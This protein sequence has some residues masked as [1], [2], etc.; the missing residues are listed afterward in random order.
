MSDEPPLMPKTIRQTVTFRAS[1]HD[2]YEALMD[3]RRHAKFTGGTAK[4]SRKLGGTFSVFDGYA[5]GKNLELVPDRK[6]VQ[7]WRASDWPEGHYST[8]TFA[9]KKVSGGTRL[10]FTQSGVPEDQFTS[11]KQ[12][13][14][15]FYWTPM[16]TFFAGRR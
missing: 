11:V 8:I 2:V 5:E 4:I 16:K 9:L 1:P 15:E 3:S 6:I 12:G 13:W 14:I 10:T 7:S